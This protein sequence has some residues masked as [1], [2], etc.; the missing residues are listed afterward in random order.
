[1]FAQLR[2]SFARHCLDWTEREYHL[3]GNLGMALLDYFIDNRL[4]IRA[5]RKP[6][7]VVLTTKGKAWLR[8]HLSL[9]L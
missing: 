6:R 8:S 2:R 4:L 1:V 5:K 3:V 9:E 7:V